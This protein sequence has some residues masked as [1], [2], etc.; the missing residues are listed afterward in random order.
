MHSYPSE[1][2]I[3][4]RKI[5]LS[6]VLINSNQILNF[7]VKKILFNYTVFIYNTKTLIIN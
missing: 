4:P 7:T 2:F 3:E 1:M 6:D 5:T